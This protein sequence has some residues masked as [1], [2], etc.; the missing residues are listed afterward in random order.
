M[1]HSN[2]LGMA[3]DATGETAPT[4]QTDERAEGRINPEQQHLDPDAVTRDEQAEA[5]KEAETS[6]QTDSSQFSKRQPETKKSSETSDP[7]RARTA[8]P[9]SNPVVKGSSTAP[10]TD[11]PGKAE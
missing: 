3:T 9:R 5:E 2:Q 7:K 11:G 8:E 10:S 1:P 4:H 6:A